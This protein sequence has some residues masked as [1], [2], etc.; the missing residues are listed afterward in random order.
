MITLHW[1]SLKLCIAATK[2]VL[3]GTGLASNVGGLTAVSKHT[4]A[5][6]INSAAL[7]V[8]GKPVCSPLCRL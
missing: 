2:A 5:K 3:Q 7:E 8:K 4:T 6:S 1:A